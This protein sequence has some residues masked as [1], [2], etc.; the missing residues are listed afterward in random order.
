MEIKK[1]FETM[2]YGPAPES[3]TAAFDWLKKHNQNFNLFI[4]GKW[5]EPLSKKHFNSENPANKKHARLFAVHEG[6]IRF[7][8]IRVMLDSLLSQPCQHLL[9]LLRPV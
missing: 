6:A 7:Q 4:D 3:A 9:F 8:P 1:I 2:E 5:Q